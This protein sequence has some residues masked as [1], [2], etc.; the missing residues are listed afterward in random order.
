LLTAIAKPRGWIDAIR[1]SR[2][3]SFAEIA[4]QEVV[5][6]RHIRLLT[7]SLSY[8]LASLPQSLMVPRRQ[9]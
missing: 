4:G 6:E 8:R 7:P 9:I 2:C 3:A 5:G 1:L